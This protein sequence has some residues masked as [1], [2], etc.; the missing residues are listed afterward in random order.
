MARISS[1][2]KN[3]RLMNKCPAGGVKKQVECALKHY[4]KKNCSKLY[5][6]E[7][8]PI[9]VC[10]NHLPK[11]AI[12]YKKSSPARYKALKEDRTL[13]KF[14]PALAL[15]AAQHMVQFTKHTNK[16]LGAIH[17]KYELQK[18]TKEVLKKFL[19]GCFTNLG[20]SKAEVKSGK[21]SILPYIQKLFADTQER[22]MEDVVSAHMARML[23]DSRTH[24]TI[25]N[26]PK[27]EAKQFVDSLL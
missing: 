15:A 27:E 1:A 22:Y 21:S 3:S 10:L 6:G 12:K 23:V 25:H 8:T 24:K 11:A 7:K 19:H 13:I 9:T 18:I 14:C 17:Q 4:M 5:K 2:V 16:Q 26:S 20:I